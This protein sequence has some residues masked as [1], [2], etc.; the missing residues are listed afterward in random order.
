MD[1]RPPPLDWARTEQ[2]QEHMME[3]EFTSPDAY[4]AIGDEV[5]PPPKVVRTFAK[6][7]GRSLA[8]YEAQR[9]AAEMIGLF[10]NYGVPV[11]DELAAA[12]GDLALAAA[13][14]RAERERSEKRSD[15]AT[16][17]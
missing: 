12:A 8:E 7:S 9:L 2:G 15:P 11:T 3:A 10:R 4:S 16:G 17:R 1:D 14:T 5:L 13:L 6:A